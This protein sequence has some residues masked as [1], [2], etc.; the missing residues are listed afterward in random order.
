VN[1][2]TALRW[3]MQQLALPQNGARAGPKP[4]R[5]K[6]EVVGGAHRGA[7]LVLD[8]PDY[9]IGSSPNADIVL[10]D[11]GIAPE[12][13][14]LHVERGMVRIGASG[15]DIMVEQE[16]VPLSRGCRVKLPASFSLGAAEIIL[17]DADQADAG[18][19][20]TGRSRTDA[21]PARADSRWRR[22]VDLA[23]AKPLPAAGVLACIILSGAFVIGRVM[24]PGSTGTS[25]RVPP[26]VTA[27]APGSTTEAALRE[28]AEEAMGE[29]KTRLAAANIDTLET[30]TE[31]GRLTVTG[32]LATK[33]AEADWAAIRQW[34]DETYGRRLVLSRIE[35]PPK[36]MSMPA[37]QIGGVWYGEHPYIVT[38]NGEHYFNGAILENGWI[39]RDIGAERV[40]LAKDGET[41]TLT[42]RSPQ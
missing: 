35:P 12:H 15:A 5:L 8:G 27:N 42:Y 3:A 20:G 25:G 18:E 24:M 33:R 29:L 28:V 39:I 21:I 30:S 23:I 36:A 10:S 37:L 17:S 4:S 34:F 38:G 41:V 2:S 9:R 22:L 40:V 14:V 7:V 11:P 26:P 19:A 13:A 6:L 31:N 32:A 1:A 16:P